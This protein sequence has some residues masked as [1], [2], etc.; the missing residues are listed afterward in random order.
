MVVVCNPP[1]YDYEEEHI[2]NRTIGEKESYTKNG[3]V[4]FI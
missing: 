2:V 4:G 3:E 1:F